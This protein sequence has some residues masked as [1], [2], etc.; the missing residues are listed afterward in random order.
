VSGVAVLTLIVCGLSALFLFT[1]DKND[2]DGTAPATPPAAAAP[3]PT[4]TSGPQ[5]DLPDAEAAPPSPV[6]APLP[7]TEPQLNLTAKTVPVAGPTFGGVEPGTELIVTRGWPFAFRIPAGWNCVTST[8]AGVPDAHAL[9]CEPQGGRLASASIVLRHCPWTC[10]PDE[11]KVMD[12]VWYGGGKAEHRSDTT[13]TYIETPA[14]PGQSYALSMSHYFG[15]SD[16]QLRWQVGV[17]IGGDEALRDDL[18]KILNDVRTQ[19][20]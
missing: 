5:Q 11:Q 13:T 15:P 12:L 2:D 7:S 10:Q 1:G 9:R 4:A 14:K 18:Q 8:F 17:R 16:G 19:A 6:P 20:G 3:Q